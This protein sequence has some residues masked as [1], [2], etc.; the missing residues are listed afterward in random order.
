MSELN[1][2]EGPA[3]GAEQGIS[4][5]GTSQ[6]K[7]PEA[8]AVIRLVCWSSGIEGER[9]E[10][11]VEVRAVVQG[12]MGFKDDWLFLQLRWEPQRAVSRGMCSDSGVHTTPGCRG[13]SRLEWAVRGVQGKRQQ[14]QCPG[15]QG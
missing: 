5:R 15:R 11:G 2:A 3:K 12:L 14:W 9:K 8:D 1:D 4:G 13:E 7:G 6:C 10:S